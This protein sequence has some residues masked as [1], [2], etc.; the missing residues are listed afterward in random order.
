MLYSHALSV[1][2]FAVC[3][4]RNSY[5]AGS[6]ECRD[7][8]MCFNGTLDIPP[9]LYMPLSQDG[10]G[11]LYRLNGVGLSFMMS[12]LPHLMLCRTTDSEPV[13]SQTSRIRL[14][15]KYDC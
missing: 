15:V 13:R 12:F 5:S 10:V 3:G 7:L 2:E 4:S 9:V 11:P 8:P 6:D 14:L 1:S